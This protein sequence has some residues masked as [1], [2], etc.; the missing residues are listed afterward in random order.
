MRKHEA[1]PSKY[2]KAADLSGPTRATV[3]SVTHEAMRD[4][5]LRPVIYSDDLP[6]PVVVN[7]TNADVLYRLAGTDDDADWPDLTFELYTEMVR[8]PS[9]GETGPA[10]RFRPPRQPQ[11][12]KTRK[13]KR[14]EAA[15]NY[16]EADPPPNL[17]EYLDDQ[18]PLFEDQES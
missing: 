16:T 8:N 5:T 4:G 6:K 3:R 13:R 7:V 10:I 15:P 1:Y 17:G 18:V 14:T 9:S 12:V 2:L 11:P